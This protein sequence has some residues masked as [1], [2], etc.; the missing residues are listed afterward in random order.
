MSSS[1]RPRLAPQPNPL[2]DMLMLVLRIALGVVFL[3]A[4]HDKILHPAAF[5]KIVHD[6]QLLPDA[7]VN[8]TALLLPW[9]E[10]MAGLAL[11][12]NIMGRGGA[13]IIVFLLLVFLGALGFN[14]YRGLNVACG[15]FSTKAQTTPL[16][17]ELARDLGLLV[18]SLLVTVRLF[19]RRRS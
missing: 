3:W 15:C 8:L 18:V 12:F 17:I 5:A 6:Y 2:L 19:R 4:A 9:I 7:L 13:L 14:A 1:L 10:V 16:V 11:V